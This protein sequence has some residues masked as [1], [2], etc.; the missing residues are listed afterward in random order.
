M[1]IQSNDKPLTGAF[2]NIFEQAAQITKSH[3]YDI[4]VQQVGELKE[5]LTKSN[6]EVERLKDALRNIKSLKYQTG[7]SRIYIES[8]LAIATQALNQ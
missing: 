3:A 1:P 8:I 2:S 4:L 7:A 6:E 5:Q